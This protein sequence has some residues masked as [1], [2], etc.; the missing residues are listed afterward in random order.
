MNAN[1]EILI[2]KLSQLFPTL[3]K[4]PKLLEE[5]LQESQLLELE[6]G[7]SIVETGKNIQ[8]IPLVLFGSLKVYR[9]NESGNELYLYHIGKGDVCVA[10]FHCTH[11]VN[12][13][14][15]KAVAVDDSEI[16]AIPAKLMPTLLKNHPSWFQFVI[17]QWQLKFEDLLVSI[18]EIAYNHLD[19]RLLQY[20]EKHTKA[21]KTN[22]L[23]L[24]H[25][26]IAQEI[27]SK[28]EVISRLLKKLEQEKVLTLGRNKI[29]LIRTNEI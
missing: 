4:D 13:S 18:D 11:S 5:I 12:L 20:L 25:A 1:S 15:I 24:T 22:V 28:R 7:K 6:E 23:K 21:E 14:K 2:H 17:D 3:S 19:Q 10:S 26:Q 9:E 29:T 8:I 16:L 27:G